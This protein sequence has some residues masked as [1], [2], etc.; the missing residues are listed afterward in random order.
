MQAEAIVIYLEEEEKKKY[1][2]IFFFQN[3]QYYIT[4]L[5]YYTIQYYFKL[6]TGRDLHWKL[7]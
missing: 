1:I 4:G 3:I 7:Q 5:Q 2:K 6:L